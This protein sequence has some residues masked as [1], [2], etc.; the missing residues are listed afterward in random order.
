MR[1][2]G[3]LEVQILGGNDATVTQ[4]TADT[5]QDR[6]RLDEPHN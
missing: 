4:D 6:D 1:L 3:A 2:T 5:G